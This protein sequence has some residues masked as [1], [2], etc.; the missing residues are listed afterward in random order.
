MIRPKGIESR[1]DEISSVTMGGYTV[2]F[3]LISNGM[4]YI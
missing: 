2:Q 4:I 1:G 3:K